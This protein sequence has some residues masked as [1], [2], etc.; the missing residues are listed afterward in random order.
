MLILGALARMA[1]IVLSMAPFCDLSVVYVGHDLHSIYDLSIYF[2][3]D[4]LASSYT[5]PTKT[6]ESTS[7]RH[8]PDTFASDW[9][10]ID[11]NSRAF[12]IWVGYG[13]SLS[14]SH[15]YRMG[16]M[17]LSLIARFIRPTCGTDGTDRT[18]VGPMLAA[19]T[20][21][22]GIAYINSISCTNP[23]QVLSSHH[24]SMA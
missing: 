15:T 22:S 11:I 5:Q 24:T 17:S 2:N 3:T 14:S 1:G 23:W 16:Y 18:Q 21:L 9:C 13:E 8:R 4:A 10:L 6:L 12:A 20:L 7:I 19:W